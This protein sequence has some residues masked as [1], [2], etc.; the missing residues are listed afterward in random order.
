MTQIQQRILEHCRRF[1]PASVSE[2]EQDLGVTDDLS[3]AVME[4]MQKGL[5]EKRVTPL[6]SKYMAVEVAT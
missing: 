2:I 3:S 5:L 4:L 1:H 6:R